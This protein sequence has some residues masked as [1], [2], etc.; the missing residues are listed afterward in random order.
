M[1]KSKETV[2]KVKSLFGL[3]V[4]E[5][6]LW[7]ALLSKGVAA[8]GELSDIS[9][10]PRSRT[11][12]VLESLEKKGF[13][14]MKLGKPIKYIAV[15]PEEVVGRVKKTIEQEQEEKIKV[16]DKLPE[17][18]MFDELSLLYK[19][20][21]E[22]VDV[23]SLSGAVKGKNNVHSHLQ[24]M[25]NKADESIVIVT[26]E[27]GLITKYNEFK[28]SFDKLNKRGVKVKIAAPITVRNKIYAEKLKEFAEVRNAKGINA[29]ICIIDG[30]D[31]TFMLNDT[32]V[33]DN[34]QIG[35]WANTPFFAQALQNLVEFNWGSWEKV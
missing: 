28:R 22:H 12:D 30:K 16:L 17:S 1:L 20:G 35:I 33:H 34:S 21:V 13:V 23:N 27:D 14:I 26:S 7:L 25:L 29:R 24:S 10:V 9:N 31:V 32:K 5:V 18:S 15:K 11:Y 2:D 4:Y 6:N 3:N 19:H 8:A